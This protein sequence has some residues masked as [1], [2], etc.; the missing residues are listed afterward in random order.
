MPNAF[1]ETKVLFLMAGPPRGDIVLSGKATT[2]GQ[3][4]L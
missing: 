3:S 2:L 1:F 4:E